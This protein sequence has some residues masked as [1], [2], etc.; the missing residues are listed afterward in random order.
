MGQEEMKMAALSGEIQEKWNKVIENFTKNIDKEDEKYISVKDAFLEKFSEYGF[1]LEDVK[2]FEKCSRDLDDVIKKIAEI[3]RINKTLL[4]KYNDDAKFVRIHKR[5][6]EENNRRAKGNILISKYDE[7]I[8]EILLK[9]KTEIDQK[10]Y[11]RNDILKKDSYFEQTV[12][13]LISNIF[14][15][16]NL[17]T[18]RE[19]RQYIQQKITKEYLEQYNNT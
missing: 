3:N 14:E 12:M 19:D 6:R 5:I 11:Y 9:I 4:N 2:Q 18:K 13:T 10:V 1:V 7:E 8:L 15:E 17:K 16:Y